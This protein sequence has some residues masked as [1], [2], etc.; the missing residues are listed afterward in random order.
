MKKIYVSFVLL[1]VLLASCGGWTDA[2]KQTVLDKC[3]DDLYDCDCY[4]K[5]TMEVF[6]DPD[7]YTST[8]ENETENGEQIDA[9]W[10]KVFEDCMTE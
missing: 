7:T 6:E 10:D 4:L 3:Q 2:R 5:T 9:Y 1:S 8:L